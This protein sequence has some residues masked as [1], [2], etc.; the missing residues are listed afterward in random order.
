[1]YKLSIESEIKVKCFR[2]ESKVINSK[3]NIRAI[4]MLDAANPR[5]T[6]HSQPETLLIPLMEPD[7]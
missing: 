4:S 7:H 6:A 5:V 3:L 2:I 1:M